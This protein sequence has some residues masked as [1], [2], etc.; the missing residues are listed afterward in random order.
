MITYL[1]LQQDLFRMAGSKGNS[2][3][4]DIEVAV[5]TAISRA[6]EEFLSRDWS[7]LE[8]YTDRVYIPLAAP[9]TTGTV[10]V[11][12]DSKTVTGSGTTFT[13]DMEG[14]FIQID[15]G[16]FYEIRT[17]TS[18]TVVVLTIP[19]QSDSGSALTFSVYK[20]FYP[21]PLDFIRFKSE[22]NKLSTPGYNSESVLAYS[23]YASFAD[24]I[25]E[26]KPTW[27]GLPGNQRNNNYYD[28]GTV[29]IA[30]SGT[31]S[32]WTVSTGTLPT[33]IVD[34]EVRITGESRS[35]YINARTAATTFTTYD[36]YC[37][38]EDQT[39]TL[40]TGSVYAITPKETQLVSFSHVADTRYIFSCPYI[41]RPPEMILDTDISPIVLAGFEDAFLMKCRSKLAED[42]RTAMR[43]DQVTTL[44]A[45]AERAM[46]DAWLREQRASTINAQASVARGDRT[47]PGPSWIGR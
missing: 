3:R 25:Q 34:R 11:T 5:K 43:G 31:V 6:T 27:F 38:P 7:F 13:K 15:G 33:D 20:R 40:S 30:T 37:N 46:D 28:I 24:Q 16:E 18:A 22:E 45:S 35:Y 42:G 29:Q 44:L 23:D 8:R 2:A 17:F 9:Y 26:G 1:D 47:R 14:S 19:Y 39:H 10:T 32:T 36:V 41:K 12:Q 4:E 21:L